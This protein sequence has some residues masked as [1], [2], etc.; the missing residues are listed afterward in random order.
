MIPQRIAFGFVLLSAVF[1]APWWLTL[2][3]ALLGTFYFHDY[4]EVIA[5]GFLFDVLYGVNVGIISGFGIMGLMAGSGIFYGVL[6]A[7]RELRA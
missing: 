1:Y 7:K 5:L 4:Y 6:R 2:F 3:L